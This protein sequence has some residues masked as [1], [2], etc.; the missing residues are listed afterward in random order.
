M[1]KRLP[2]LT[3][4]IILAAAVV[5][6]L[7]GIR[8]GLPTETHYF[9]YHP[10]EALILLAALRLDLLGGG[11]DP[12]FY[13]YGSLYIFL[14]N[15]A[16]MAASILGFVSFSS[17]DFFTEIG[18]FAKIYLAGRGVAFAMGVLTVYFVYLLASRAYGRPTGVIAALF[19]AVMPLHS[20]HSKFMAVDVPA[21]L[22]VVVALLFAVRLADGRRLRDYLLAGLFA[23]LAAGTKYNAGLVVLA[24]MAAHLV[25][26]KIDSRLS[27]LKLALL[28]VMAA[29]G[30]LIG[31]PGVLL[32][33]RQFLADFAYELQ[34]TQAGH[35]IT[36][37]NT[38]SGFVYHITHNLTAAVTVPL[39]ILAGAGLVYAIWKRSTSDLILL[40]F[41]AAYYVLIGTAEVKFA[42]YT[43]PT[44]PILAVFAARFSMD[45][46]ERLRNKVARGAV[47]CIPI[48]VGAYA[49]AGTLMLNAAFSAPDTRDA[50]LDW[51]HGNIPPGASI[52]LPTTPWFYT[53][54]FDPYFGLLDANERFDRLVEVTDYVLF[55]SRNEWDAGF[56]ERESPDYVIMSEFEY[57]DRLRIGDDSARAYFDI[58]EQDYAQARTFRRSLRFIGTLPHDMSYV[59]PT[60]RVYQ[61]VR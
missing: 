28:P 22:L 46:I 14:V 24:P 18:E 7:Q 26:G 57:S 36:F 19:L 29:G 37:A 35:G 1:V 25:S 51:I 55:V 10:D 6:R 23:G 21:T 50:A 17:G 43:M 44:L 42:R 31:T 45:M 38:G 39:L 34:H 32:N 12:G 53:P 58:L 30:F 8:W 61:R 5:L 60:V 9:S 2:F 56:L 52:A 40:S 54:P 33:T 27:G 11:F 49:M 20:M 4:L 3:M 13:N 59:S 47:A 41:L 48:A 16:S 15:I